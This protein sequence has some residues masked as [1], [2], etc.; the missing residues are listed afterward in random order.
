M[1]QTLGNVAH[2]IIGMLSWLWV[3]L[4]ALA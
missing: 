4:A 3:L 1:A 2:L